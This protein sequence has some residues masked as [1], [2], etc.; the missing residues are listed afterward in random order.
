[1]KTIRPGI[2]RSLRFLNLLLLN[3]HSLSRRLQK[4][5]FW[6]SRLAN[7]RVPKIGLRSVVV[8]SVALGAWLI[9][10]HPLPGTPWA[11]GMMAAAAAGQERDAKRDAW[12]RPGEVFD[13]LGIGAGSAV[14]DVGC[15][16][17]YFVY[18][19]ARRVGSDGVVYAEDVDEQAL[20]TVRRHAHKEKFANVRLVHGSSNDP[21]LPAG[22]M[23]AVLVV[24][25]YH[26]FLEYDAMLKGMARALKAGG[27]L[28]IIDAAGDET[29]TRAEHQNKH[30]ITE[31][32]VMEDAARNGFKLRSRER[33][34]TR[35][36]G[37]R[38]E[39]FFLIFEPAGET[40]GK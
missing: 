8:V 1:M 37:D 6:S 14:A 36:D 10:V 12:Q 2:L 19:L 35:P 33:G 15:G 11:P 26:E 30:T 18:R 13:A 4:I 22:A 40:S 24:N 20:A 39:Y 21:Q 38:H 5:P 9:F 7:I 3:F 16:D 23:D 25:A 27:R 29:R 32:L 31:K 17:G 34:F 28:G